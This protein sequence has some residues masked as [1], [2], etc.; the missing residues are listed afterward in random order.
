MR[1]EVRGVDAFNDRLA[2][3]AQRMDRAT[4]VGVDDGLT[5]V[6]EEATRLLTEKTHPPGTPT[7]SVAPEPPA[8]ISGALRRSIRARRDPSSGGVHRGRIGPTI[9]YGR[10][11]ELGGTIVPK[12]AKQLS[13]LTAEGWRHAMSVRL[14]A[15]PYMKPAVTTSRPRVRSRFVELWRQAWRL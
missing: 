10:I 6:Q 14:P 7:P 1:W 3:L 13:W 9:V 11:Q 8:L 4:D 2:E 5:L 15:R 12:V